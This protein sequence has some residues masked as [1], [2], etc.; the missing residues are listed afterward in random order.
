[1]YYYV[2]ML[3]GLKNPGA[4]Y[5][6]CMQKCFINR[7]NPPWQPHQLEPPKTTIAVDVDDVAVK[8]PRASDLIAMVDATFANLRRFSIKLNLEKCTFG[9]PKGKL[10]G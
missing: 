8:V 6:C 7:I 4:T 3:F 2:T 9:L 10:L 1:M 5:Q